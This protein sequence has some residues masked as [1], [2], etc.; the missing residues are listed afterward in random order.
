MTSLEDITTSIDL[1]LE[2]G[3][4]DRFDMIK[5]VLDFH[6]AGEDNNKM[7]L[8]FLLLGNFSPKLMNCVLVRGDSSGGKNHLVNNVLK[9]FPQKKV[10][11]FD[12]AT[13]AALRYD[14]DLAGNNILYLRE[15]QEQIT[16]VEFLKA[17]YNDKLIH[18]ETVRDPETGSQKVITHEYDKMGI[19]TTFSFENI[20]IDLVNRSWVLSPDQGHSQTTK[21]IEHTL[22]KERNLI[23]RSVKEQ[24]IRDRS[25]FISQCITALDF[26]YEPYIC[27]VNKLRTLFPNEHLNVRRDMNKLIQLIKIICIW[28]QKSRRTLERGD[29]RFIFAEFKDL[30]MAL[31][32]CQDLFLNV[33]LHIDSTKRLILDLAKV[34]QDKAEPE[35]GMPEE[36]TITEAYEMLREQIGITRKT[37]QRKMNDLFYEGYLLREKAGNKYVFTLLKGYDII[38]ALNLN[39]LREELETM[40]SNRYRYFTETKEEV[41]LFE[42]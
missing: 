33:V 12:S 27:F 30:E 25:F 35:A 42:G 21:I 20:Q 29:D 22:D 10:Y 8:F 37:V 17:F 9:L 13:A 6:I 24:E 4:D 28:N 18:K 3:A 41:I 16:L 34:R 36:I 40:V 14:D 39:D 5:E 23:M 31:R 26:D 38:E 32:I 7:L 15:L 11:I 19:V 1:F 2:K